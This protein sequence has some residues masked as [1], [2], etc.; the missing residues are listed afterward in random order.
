M[1]GEIQ[2][3]SNVLLLKSGENIPYGDNLTKEQMEIVIGMTIEKFDSLVK[4]FTSIALYS[5]ND[6]S[7]YSIVFGSG[8]VS[9]KESIE[10]DMIGMEA[11]FNATVDEN[12][13]REFILLYRKSTKE[14]IQGSF[15]AVE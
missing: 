5:I 1:G 4:N 14:Y 11:V 6:S 2:G 15:T 7:S 13:R 9:V 10:E 3:N 12:I 8:I